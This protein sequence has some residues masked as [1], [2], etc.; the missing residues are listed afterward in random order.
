MAAVMG[1]GQWGDSSR[2]GHKVAGGPQPCVAQGLPRPYVGQDCL[3]A[4][5]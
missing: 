5:Q 1:V 3:S 2:A 4:P